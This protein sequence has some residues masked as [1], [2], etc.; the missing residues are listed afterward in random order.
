MDY[1]SSMSGGVLLHDTLV[2][3]ESGYG[4]EVLPLGLCGRIGKG[5][6]ILEGKVTSEKPDS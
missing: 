2:R 3:L 1:I 5:V 4:A 6:S